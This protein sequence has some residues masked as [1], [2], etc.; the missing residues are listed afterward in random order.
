[1]QMWILVARAGVIGPEHAHAE[2]PQRIAPSSSSRRERNAEPVRSSPQ[3]PLVEADSR[4]HR[5]DHLPHRQ[6]AQDGR[7]A[8]DVVA[9]RVRGH[10]C[11][12]S[13]Q[14][15]PSELAIDPSLGWPC[16]HEQR[17]LR[18]LEENAVPLS[19]IEERDA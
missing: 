6:P 17:A 1:M 9:V 16:I 14:P 11:S 10:E 3:L 13:V 2:P 19:D 12:E 7:R 4:L 8:S 15:P 18:C 5:I